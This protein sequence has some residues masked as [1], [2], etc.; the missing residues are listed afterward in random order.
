V[1]NGG[2]WTALDIEKLLAEWH[3][4][5]QRLEKM[6]PSPERE[7]LD[8]RCARLAETYRAAVRSRANQ[9]R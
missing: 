1:A 7:A 8:A 4:C 3:E 5:E 9:Q 2:G 6:Q